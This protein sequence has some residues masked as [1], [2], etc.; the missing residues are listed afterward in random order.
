MNYLETIS[1]QYKFDE[2][3]RCELSSKF[4]IILLKFDT[5]ESTS[6][7]AVSLHRMLIILHFIVS[8]SMEIAW[9]NYLSFADGK[10]LARS[11]KCE[12]IYSQKLRIDLRAQLTLL[13]S[14]HC[15]LF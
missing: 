7:T 8:L 4:D 10:L 14:I 3:Y 15:C 2:R 5:I 11:I 12:L 6:T 9:D 1:I 13:F